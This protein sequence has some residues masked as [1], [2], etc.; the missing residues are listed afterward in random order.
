M[1]QGSEEWLEARRGKVTASR[2]ADLTA[3]TKSG[4]G[5]SRKNYEAQLIA[6]IRGCGR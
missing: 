6:D 1:E 2:I 5:A 4:W 3:K